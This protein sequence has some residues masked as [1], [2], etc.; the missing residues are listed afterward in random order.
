TAGATAAA[1]EPLTAPA[2]NNAQ[3]SAAP[4]SPAASTETVPVEGTGSGGAGENVAGE[5]EHVNN[6]ASELPPAADGKIPQ[7][8]EE[9]A[10]NAQRRREN[11]RRLEKERIRTEERRAA[12]AEFAAKEDAI[13]ASMALEDPFTGKII[14]NKA[15]YDAYIRARDDAEIKVGL[16]NAGL[17][18]SAIDALIS[19]HPDIIKA[20]ELAAKSAA[21]T[22]RAQSL[23][24]EEHAKAELALITKMDPGIK[25]I[26]DLRASD[27]YEAVYAKVRDN[28]LT[29]S[30]AFRII[31]ADAI[32]QRKIN[33]ALQQQLNTARGKEHL[34]GADQGHGSGGIVM[35]EKVRRGYQAAFPGLS[36]EALQQKYER[37]ILSQR[38]G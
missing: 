34:A 25:T 26:E 8:E 20:R 6:T 27:T 5:G 24:A 23:S 22:E 31:N 4:T 9:R 13:Y 18:R 17:E 21:E 32:E 2:A 14:T 36:A 11:E 33:A 7:S 1:K 3:A 28:G 15:E 10:A 12:Q 29:I 16:E 30:E 35:P 37:L 38:K 19:N